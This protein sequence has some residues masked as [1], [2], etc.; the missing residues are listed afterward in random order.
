MFFY[1]RL[2]IFISAG[3]QEDFLWYAFFMG[4][5]LTKNVGQHDWP[6]GKNFKKYCLKRP[7]VA[8]QKRKFGLKYK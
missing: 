2:N 4:E 3:P 5:G 8:P 6:T 1:I 7:K